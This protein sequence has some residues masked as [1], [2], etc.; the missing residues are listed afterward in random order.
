MSYIE[1][2]TVTVDYPILDVSRRSFKKDALSWVTG[3][4]LG[5]NTKHMSVRA[6]DNINLSIASGEKIGLLG[7]NGSGKSTLLKVFAGVY[8]PTSGNINSSGKITSLL[9]LTLGME[10]E[11]TGYENIFLRGVIMGMSPK[12][13]KKTVKD[14][15]EFSGL[16]DYLKLPIRTYSSGMLVRLGFSISTAFPA[17]I[18]LMDEWLGVGD[19]KF[20]EEANKRLQEMT[21]N[22]A[23]LVLASHSPE[24]INETCN[25][26]VRLEHGKIVDDYLIGAAA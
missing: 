18:I 13:I 14:I 10:M 23:I 25:R 24:L 3:G 9:D 12:H 19:A 22:A 6:L 21:Q 20:Q 7:H 5:N 4:S 2:K 16:G 11:A 8:H 17:D 26:C 15:A 1:T